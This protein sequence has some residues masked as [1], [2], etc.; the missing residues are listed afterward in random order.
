MNFRRAILG[1]ELK[2]LY[3]ELIIKII[4]HIFL[5]GTR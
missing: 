1:W 4:F 3:P 5:R 2:D